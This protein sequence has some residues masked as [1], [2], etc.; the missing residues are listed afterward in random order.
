MME[1]FPLHVLFGSICDGFPFSLKE[2]ASLKLVS[3]DFNK[4]ASEH[5][6]VKAA[7]SKNLKQL[8][9]V[10]LA[11]DHTK[12]FTDVVI[13]S[14]I[15]LS[16]LE[17]M[18]HVWDQM[19]TRKYG[20]K[21]GSLFKQHLTKSDPSVDRCMNT[22]YVLNCMYILGR[23]QMKTQRFAPTD[24]ARYVI[25]WISDYVK[26]IFSKMHPTIPCVIPFADLYK[27]AEYYSPRMDVYNVY[28]CVL[29]AFDRGDGYAKL[30]TELVTHD[31]SAFQNSLSM[32]L[33]IYSAIGTY[34]NID[35]QDKII[36]YIMTFIYNSF[37]RIRIEDVPIGLAHVIKNKA[38]DLIHSIQN[39]TESVVRKNI[40]A[41]CAELLTMFAF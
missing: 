5:F 39:D 7:L 8:V 22:L 38:F 32:W 33:H 31:V 29:H 25:F 11:Y 27:N 21:Y 17:R 26:R 16:E 35:V 13:N 23:S 19:T 34:N 4:H 30:A 6:V 40:R 41:V 2:T 28:E 20:E 12:D 37:H 14:D 15:C 24:L 3:K 18:L 10:S 36:L 9:D 1:T